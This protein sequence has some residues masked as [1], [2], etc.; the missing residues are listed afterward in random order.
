MANLFEVLEID[1]LLI[2]DGFNGRTAALVATTTSITIATAL[3]A[4][5]VIDGVTLV[6][7]DRVLVKDQG[8]S[9]ITDFDYSGFITPTPAATGL[10]FTLAS[11]Q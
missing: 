3:N 8:V 1:N 5:D 6:A 10:H 2:G 7:D 4:G 11:P 9:E